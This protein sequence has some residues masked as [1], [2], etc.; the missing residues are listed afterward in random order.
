MNF[1]SYEC[2]PTGRDTVVIFMPIAPPCLELNDSCT[3]HSVTLHYYRPNM[4][5]FLTIGISNYFLSIYNI[6]IIQV[7]RGYISRFTSATG[8]M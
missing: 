6:T 4:P 8:G 3:K 1:L 7:D 5:F 2:S